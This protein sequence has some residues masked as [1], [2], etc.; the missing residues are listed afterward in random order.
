M[1]VSPALIRRLSQDLPQMVMLKHEDWPGLTKM[2]AL[3]DREADPAVAR[4]S[5]LC[6]NGGL[7]LP[8]ELARGADGG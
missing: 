2:S 1:A 5:I 6:G 8:L 7:Y 4:L 3:R